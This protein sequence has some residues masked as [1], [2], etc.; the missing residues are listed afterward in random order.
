MVSHPRPHVENFVRNFRFSAQLVDL[1]DMGLV[2][3]LRLDGGTARVEL[4]VT[5]PLCTQIG[6]IVE[7]GPG[8][9]GGGGRS[10]FGGGN[11]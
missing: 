11:R 5:S 9:P 7:P 2:K 1:L 6:L 3:D 10:W 4:V 8:G